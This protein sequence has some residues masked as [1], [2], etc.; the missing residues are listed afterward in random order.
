MMCV[1]AIH[2]EA[3]MAHHWREKEKNYGGSRFN[4]LQAGAIEEEAPSAESI[5]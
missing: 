1:S 3:I 5:D 4:S 2:L